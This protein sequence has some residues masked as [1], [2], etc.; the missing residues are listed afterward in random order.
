MSGTLETV[1]NALYVFSGELFKL[2]T[3]T[4]EQQRNHDDQLRMLRARQEHEPVGNTL[5]YDFESKP[6]RAIMSPPSYSRRNEMSAVRHQ[7]SRGTCTAFGVAAQHEFNWSR[8]KDFSEQFLYWGSKQIDNS[9]EGTWI[10]DAWESLKARGTCLESSAPYTSTQPFPKWGGPDLG[11]AAQTEAFNYKGKQNWWLDHTNLDA[12]K[13]V[14]AD[15][16]YVVTIQV[17]VWWSSWPSSGIIQMP[18][19][20]DMRKTREIIKSISTDES[21]P[22]DGEHVICLCGYNDSTQR[23]EFKNSWGVNWGSGGFGSIP[24]EYI[25]QYSRDATVFQSA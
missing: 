8:T 3:F 9:S 22:S 17:T 18:T 21:S 14:I 23:F 25:K 13:K 15:L 4:K 24:Y 19:A 7:G 12:L 20:V 5:P 16:G 6:P 11:S 10:K 1:D 2:M